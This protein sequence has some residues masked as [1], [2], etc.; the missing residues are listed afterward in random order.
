MRGRNGVFRSWVVFVAVW[1]LVGLGKAGFAASTASASGNWIDLTLYCGSGVCVP[2][3]TNHKTHAEVNYL[4]GGG[5]PAGFRHV[6]W[7]DFGGSLFPKSS[8]CGNY[9]WRKGSTWYVTNNGNVTIGGWWSTGAWCN[10]STLCKNYF[11]D[12]DYG[13]MC[14]GSCKGKFKSATWFTSRCVPNLITHTTT[15]SF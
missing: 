14:S 1:A 5:L 12:N 7:Q 11:S 10:S 13:I 6:F 3:G 2:Y 8:F 4:R 15:V 9:D